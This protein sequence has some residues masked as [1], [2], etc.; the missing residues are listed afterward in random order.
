MNQTDS[1]DPGPILNA[2]RRFNLVDHGDQPQIIRLYQGGSQALHLARL[3]TEPVYIK[4]ALPGNGDDPRDPASRV[5][6]EAGYHR[7]GMDSALPGGAPMIHGVDES[8]GL[9]VMEFI[10]PARNKPWAGEL[11]EGDINLEFTR[12]VGARLCGLHA[13]SAGQ[14]G[15]ASE[16]T[17]DKDFFLLCL[18]PSLESASCEHPEAAQALADICEEAM[19][20][21]L[22][23]VHGC[24]DPSQV[25]IGP[26]G[27]VF[28]GGDRAWFGDP[29][30][31]IAFLLSRLF[32]L[33]LSRRWAMPELKKDFACLISSYLA[34]VDWEPA[35]A[36]EQ[37]ASRML[38][39]MLLSGVDGDKSQ[40]DAGDGARAGRVRRLGL[41]LIQP[42]E[43]SL[44]EV[45]QKWIEVAKD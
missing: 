5:I 2:L 1:F 9:L 37:R 23:L 33:S 43:T 35:K 41:K 26:K 40:I 31:D 8:H 13:A 36:L 19:A 14:R 11:M 39:G 45:L 24:L 6:C 27:P 10:S 32:F 25:L 28:M 20:Q 29:A 12:Q 15:L 4:Q 16:F 17:R 3:E 21:K 18:G 30:Y 38:G 7:H 42:A 44:D 34:G 22:T